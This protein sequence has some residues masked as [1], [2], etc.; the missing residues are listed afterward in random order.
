[1]PRHGTVPVDERSSLC[2]A[3][4]AGHSCLVFE[5][6]GPSKLFYSSYEVVVVRVVPRSRLA[7]LRS[8]S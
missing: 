2:L 1:M 7:A 6:L 8:G 5:G 4:G 3:T